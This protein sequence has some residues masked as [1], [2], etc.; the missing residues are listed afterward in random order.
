MTVLFQKPALQSSVCSQWVPFCCLHRHFSY[1]LAAVK[2]MCCW[3]WSCCYRTREQGDSGNLN[4]VLRF[5]PSKFP[6]YLGAK[7]SLPSPCLQYRNTGNGASCPTASAQRTVVGWPWPALSPHQPFFFFL[8]F[9]LF[10]FVCTKVHW[11]ILHYLNPFDQE[12]LPTGQDAA[13]IL[14]LLAVE[15][16]VMFAL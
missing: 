4:S 14:L 3:W 1:S 9:C 7:Q 16:C 6:M 11:S 15:Q 2:P 10:V 8:F 13:C 12:A 5:N